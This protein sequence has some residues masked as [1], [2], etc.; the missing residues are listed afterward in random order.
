MNYFPGLV[1]NISLTRV[2]EDGDFALRI[3][4]SSKPPKD[5]KL[6]GIINGIPVWVKVVDQAVAL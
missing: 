3:D 4:L 5:V 1:K 6:P 2:R